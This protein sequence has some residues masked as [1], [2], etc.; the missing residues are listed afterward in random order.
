MVLLRSLILF[1]M[2]CQAV[3]AQA[4][5]FRICGWLGEDAAAPDPLEGDRMP[6][7]RPD[8]PGVAHLARRGMSADADKPLAHCGAVLVAPGWIVTAR[9]CV[10]DMIWQDMQVDLGTTALGSKGQGVIRRGTL[11]LCPAA[12]QPGSLDG[13][14][15]LV[16]LDRRAPDEISRPPLLRD[17]DPG[18][19]GFPGPVALA[20]WPAAGLTV[21]TP[22]LRVLALTAVAVTPVGH[23]VAQIAEAGSRPPCGGESGSPVYI[24]H[25]GQT[26]L[27]GVLSAIATPS[28]WEQ[29]GRAKCLAPQTRVLFSPVA[30]WADWIADSIAACEARPEICVRP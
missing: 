13:D 18:V 10:D 29:S 12:T 24:D 19:F 1:L 23:V 2:V 14:V 28:W 21:G 16:R 26:Q 8:A 20:S 15:A 9:H 6:R 3:T 5:D 17:P 4:A 30:P 7:Q 11:A 27:A 25:D 22:N